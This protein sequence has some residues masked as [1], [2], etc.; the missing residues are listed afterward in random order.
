MFK[1]ITSQG[2]IRYLQYWTNDRNLKMYYQKSSIFP[3]NYKMGIYYQWDSQQTI[4]IQISSNSTVVFR[5]LSKMMGKQNHM[6]NVKPT[7]SCLC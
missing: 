7:E 2:L 5:V 6:S 4:A 3:F 1:M